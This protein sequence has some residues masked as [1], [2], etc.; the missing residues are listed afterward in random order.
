MTTAVAVA[1]TEC[2]DEAELADYCLPCAYRQPAATWTS[3]FAAQ[4]AASLHGLTEPRLWTRPLVELTPETSLGFECIAFATIVLGVSLDPWQCWF[5]IH[6]LELLPDGKYRFRKVLL[7]VARQNGKTTVMRV[8]TLWAIFTGRVKLAIQTAQDLDTARESWE[9]AVEIVENDPELAEQIAGPRKKATRANGKEVLKLQNGSRYKIKATTQDAGRGIPG[10]GLIVLDEMRTHR[11][12]GPWS[13]LSK[14]AMAVPDA[15][16]VM[17]SNAGDDTSV[18]L[19]DEREKALTGKSETAGIFEWSAEPGCA[20]DDRQAWAQANPSLGYGRLT[21]RALVD[22]MDDPPAV[23]RT[24]CLCQRVESLRGAVDGLAWRGGADKDGN[25]D[26]LRDR[27]FACVEL[28]EGTYGEHATL[29][30]AAINDAGK[31]VVEVVE[32]WDSYAAM[33]RDLPLWLDRLGLAIGKPTEGVEPYGPDDKRPRTGPAGLWFFPTGPAAARAGQLRALGF[34]EIKG[35]AVQEACQGLAADVRAGQVI[36]R[37]DPLLT[38]HV[39][40]AERLISGDGWRFTR[41]G[42]VDAA[43]AAAGA[44][45]AARNHADQAYDPRDSVLWSRPAE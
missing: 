22:A 27:L 24:E 40:G 2:G 1:C 21:E 43:Y 36:H 30:V 6:A 12:R 14:T 8:L 45:W 26:D 19:N 18:V 32:A 38:A 3:R 41:G 13:S 11:D 25:M 29:C 28:A 42:N 17:M 39:V 7:L 20:L 44:V 23:F 37:D 15:L 31:A 33:E 9:E 5:L 16:L 34:K 4:P 10:V 35:A